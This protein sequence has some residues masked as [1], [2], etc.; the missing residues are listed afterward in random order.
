MM[1]VWQNFLRYNTKSMIKQTKEL[2]KI[3]LIKI[4][5]FYF[6]KNTE[7]KKAGYRLGENI[8]KAYISQ[9]SKSKRLIPRIYEDYSK[10]S[11]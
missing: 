4:K 5:N 8:C 9:R 6:K 10:L 1:L 7:H 11:N 2:H 3:N